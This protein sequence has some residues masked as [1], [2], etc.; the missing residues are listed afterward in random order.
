MGVHEVLSTTD[1]VGHYTNNRKVTGASGLR[2]T[3]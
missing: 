2:R 3:T 1:D